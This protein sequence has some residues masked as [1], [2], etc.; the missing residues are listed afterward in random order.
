MRKI[1]IGDVHGK[2]DQYQKMLRQ[3]FSTEQTIQIGD[4][5]FGFPRTPGLHKDIMGDNHKWF[6]GNHDDPAKCRA[7]IGYLGDYGFLP[8][9]NLF[10]IAGAYS[11][12]Y[13][14]RIPGHSW[15]P[16]EELSWTELDAAIEL[17]KEKKP[18]FVISHEAPGSVAAW[19]LQTVV[20]GFRPEKLVQT[21]TGSAMDRMLDYHRPEEWVF[22]HYHID[23]SFEL[24]GTKYTCVNELSS[25]I[26]TDEP[27]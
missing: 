5:G 6:R 4:M 11:I 14:W 2:T 7:T 18:R 22:G 27:K 25:Y 13:M 1:I 9:D 21:R 19:L 10:Y 8:E 3:R 23:K 24:K 17:Y 16:D 12:D 15:W 20:P 26:L